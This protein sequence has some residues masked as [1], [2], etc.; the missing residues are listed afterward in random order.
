MSQLGLGIL[1]V[2]AG[3]FLASP[4]IV[5]L[6]LVLAFADAIRQVWARRGMEGVTY[7]RRLPHPRGVAGDEIALDITVWNRKALPLA[8]LRAE[9]EASLGVVVRERDLLASGDGPDALHNAWTLAPFER[10]TRHFHVVADRRGVYSLGPARLEVGDLFARPAA[11]GTAPGVDRWLV[12]PR[13]VAVTIPEHDDPWGG[14]LRARRG[15]IADPTRYAG[16]RP[17][18]PGDPLRS[19]HWRASARLGTPVSRLFEPG[20]HREVVLALDIQTISGVGW[21]TAY[22]DDAVEGLC[23]AAA[24]L[25]RRLR[26]DGAAVGLAAAGYT[27]AMRPIAYV[28][29]GASEAQVGRCLDLLARL[30]SFPSAPFERLLTTLLRTL[31]PGTS[32]LVL[33]ARD[34]EP[35]LAVLR[36]VAVAGYPVQLLALG[37]DGAE[38][39]G[40]ARAAGI[41]A[42]VVHLDGPWRTARALVVA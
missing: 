27:G 8:W 35:Y 13:S 1:L 32:V 25:V 10:V 33:S 17:Y 37:R 2:I 40:H 36:R 11:S 39:A 12:R 24:S 38:A 3:S 5:L 29:P 22:D 34:P 30:S 20:R 18:Q 28:A 23:V 6:G 21:M 31:R 19:V 41:A 9:D 26:A 42:R 14:E 4:A 15:L 7:A 16:V